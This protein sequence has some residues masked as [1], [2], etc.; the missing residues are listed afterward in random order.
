MR[1][2]QPSRDVGRYIAQ[3]REGET[4]RQL[5]PPETPS[6]L[7]FVHD[8]ERLDGVLTRVDP[9]GGARIHGTADGAAR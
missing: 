9:R 3:T 7:G 2:G 4:D 8:L 5:R 6:G 1:W